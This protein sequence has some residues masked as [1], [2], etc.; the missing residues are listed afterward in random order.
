MRRVLFVLGLVAAAF[1]ANSAS[2]AADKAAEKFVRAAI[3]GNLAE[4]AVGKLAQDKGAN[5]GV[6]NF[7]KVLVDDHSAANEKAI[8]LANSLG[9]KV[10]TAPTKKEKAEYDRLAKLSGAAF[11]SAFVKAMVGDH[12]AAIRAF[13]RAAK[14]DGEVA[15]FAKD[16][17]PTL[18][19]HLKDAEA[20]RGGAKAKA[21]AR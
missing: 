6:R 15:Q 13:Q 20:L 14:K 10:A 11:D 9:I 18:E 1:W 21:A 4:I 5:D 2:L 17:L 19:K 12:K 8:A 3:E 7:G 16:T